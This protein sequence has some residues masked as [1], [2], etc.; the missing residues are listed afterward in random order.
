MP[1]ATTATAALTIVVPSA[2]STIASQTGGS[3]LL[4]F[5]DVAGYTYGLQ[6]TPDLL[7]PWQRL[8]PVTIGTNGL[9]EYTD[10]AH[11]GTAS[12]FYRFV[13]P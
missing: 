2:D 4:Q 10:T 6:Y 11:P 3:F 13:Y 12:G 7:Q 5:Q 1:N 8:G 9:G